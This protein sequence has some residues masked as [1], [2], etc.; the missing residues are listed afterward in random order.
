[1]FRVDFALRERT[2]SGLSREKIAGFLTSITRG[3]SKAETNVARH[4]ARGVS[5]S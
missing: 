4:Q 2:H 3:S 5:C 1:M